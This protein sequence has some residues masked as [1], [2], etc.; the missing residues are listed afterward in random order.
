VVLAN[1]SLTKRLPPES[2]GTIANVQYQQTLETSSEGPGRMTS[3][4]AFGPALD[5]DLGAISPLALGLIGNYTLGL[6]LG[7]DEGVGPRHTFGGGLFYT[8]QPHLNL[9]AEVQ[10]TLLSVPNAEATIIEA[11]FRMQYVW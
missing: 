6:P 4:L 1:D 2:L 9:G 10:T 3:Q 7:A 11:L 5:F 8:G